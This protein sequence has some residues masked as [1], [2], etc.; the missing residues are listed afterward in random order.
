MRCS[1]HWQLRSLIS[2][3]GSNTLYFACNS[4]IHRV[5]TSTR[6]REH[7]TSLPFDAR[8]LAAGYGW[9]V[10]GGPDSGQ[11]AAVKIP[12]DNEERR[13]QPSRHQLDVDAL[14]PV[15]LDPE[16][17]RE[18]HRFLSS[19]ERFGIGRRPS[20][21]IRIQELGSLIVNS[22]TLHRSP[23]DTD[24]DQDGTV[25]ILTNND[26]TVRVFSLSQD[27]LLTTLE[28]QFYMNHATI[29]PDGRLLVAVGDEPYVYFYQRVKSASDTSIRAGIRNQSSLSSYRWE[30]LTKCHLTPAL[31]PGN[32]GCFSSAFSASGQFCAVAS[33][34]GIITIFE[35]AY[36]DE[37]GQDAIIE[38]MPS[39]RPHFAAGAVRSICFSPQPWDLL[40]CTEHSGRVCV[41][42]VRT[43]FRSRQVVDLDISS[44][45]KVELSNE[46]R[47]SISAQDET[48]AARF[49]ADYIEPLLP[50]QRQTNRQAR[51][52][53]QSPQPFTERERQILDALR[54]SRE[55]MD[56][57]E[58]R[59]TSI[60][61]LSHPTGA[62]DYRE[63]LALLSGDEHLG[64]PSGGT[65]PDSRVSAPTLPAYIR[66][67]NVDR[68][69]TRTRAYEP[70]R[71]SSVILSHHDPPLPSAV[72]ELPE[73][74]ITTPPPRTLAQA[75]GL[76]PWHTIEAA[77]AAGPSPDSSV[78]LRRE[79]GTNSENSFQRREDVY[80]RLEQRRRERL[81]NLYA[82]VE[83]L[84]GSQSGSRR[85][86]DPDAGIGT[87]G[88]VMS[89]DGRKL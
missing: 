7:I 45:E 48:A 57:W 52:R 25:A 34:D 84:G 24:D 36:L 78:R 60:N 63:S 65:N 77:M 55:R 12:Q 13:E 58:Q 33:Q 81:R 51:D 68:D 14:L 83:G 75:D 22:V 31:I 66:E 61:Y 79:R 11:F 74:G 70:R 8:C 35:T 9:I 86:L 30:L 72:R 67:R 16:A 71:R 42:D 18:A 54:T 23:P 64:A 62:A 27:R 56:A 38:I 1:S 37:S 76:D 3:P 10:A 21:E 44:A 20:P 49:T 26:K 4:D 28:F 43:G 85:P 73:A 53:D 2:A 89:E 59:P 29:S 39:S 32:D 80:M 50:E 6:K 41:T 47:E 17:R 88:C 46:Y 40:I 5:N 15:N 82:E 19:E 69:R 87:A